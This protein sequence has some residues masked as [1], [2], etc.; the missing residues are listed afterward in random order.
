[1][2]PTVLAIRSISSEFARRLYVPVAVAIVIVIVTTLIAGIWLTTLSAW[3]WIL[4]AFFIMGTLI[5]STLLVVGGLIIRTIR[6][7]QTRQQ[8]KQI[9]KFVDKIQSIADLT[10]TPKI[11]ILFR[12][13][14]D[15]TAMNTRGYIQT[16][17]DDTASMHDD[18]RN[19]VR[20]FS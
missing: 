4:V 3:W 2:T 16:L 18:F 12:I 8:T 1:M 5:A 10:G 6:P 13:V 17:Y 20:S 14:R 11:V 15:M 9:S 7:V 19:I